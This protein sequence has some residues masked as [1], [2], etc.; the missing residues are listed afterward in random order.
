MTE[1]FKCEHCGR[2]FETKLGLGVHRP[3]CKQAADRTQNALMKPS[4]K[5]IH[6]GRFRRVAERVEAEVRERF[7]VDGVHVGS[8]QGEVT[9]EVWRNGVAHVG[10]VRA[11]GITV[12][13]E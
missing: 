5:P 8:Y 6:D 13:P 1:E 4:G 12:E 3:V 11:I 10:P 7:D 9:V 2:A